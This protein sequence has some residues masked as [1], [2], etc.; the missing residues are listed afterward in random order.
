MEAMIY[1]LTLSAA[2]TFTSFTGLLIYENTFGKYFF[3]IE[4]KFLSSFLP[5]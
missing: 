1:S 2:D 4:R 5:T 3:L